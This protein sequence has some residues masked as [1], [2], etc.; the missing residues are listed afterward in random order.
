[1][2]LKKSSFFLLLAVLYCS[3]FL[4]YKIAWIIRSE[5]TMGLMSFRGKSQTGALEHHYS[6]IG[7][8][9]NGDT[10]WFNGNDNIFFR[11]GEKIPVRYLKSNPNDA[12]LDIFPSMWGD[13][14]VYGIIPLSILLVLFVH[15]HIFPRGTRFRLSRTRPFVEVMPPVTA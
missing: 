15:P 7:F 8:E 9:A 1:M 13:T 6:V 5:R 2:I 10:I 12:R 14:L 3:P 4:I 11:E